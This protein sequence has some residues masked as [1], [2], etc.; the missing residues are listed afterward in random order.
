MKTEIEIIF[1]VIFLVLGT[2]FFVFNIQKYD[3]TGFAVA[4]SSLNSNDTINESIIVTKEMALQSINESEQII[5]V[6]FP[7]FT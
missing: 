3:L 5:I 6:I 2:S 4:N 1:I 7:L